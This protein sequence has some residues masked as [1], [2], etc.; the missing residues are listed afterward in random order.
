MRMLLKNIPSLLS[1]RNLSH[2]YIISK[3]WQYHLWNMPEKRD[4]RGQLEV[5]LKDNLNW[6]EHFQPNDLTSITVFRLSGPRSTY[7]LGSWSFDYETSAK[8]RHNVGTHLMGTPH[9]IHAISAH[10]EHL[11]HR[12]RTQRP[13]NVHTTSTQRWHNVRAQSAHRLATNRHLQSVH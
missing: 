11:A 6:E 4:V 2:I 3:N 5:N 1:T 12:R 7:R 8:R 13:H 9:D 10:N